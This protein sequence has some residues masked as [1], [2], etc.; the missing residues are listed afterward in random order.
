MDIIYYFSFLYV[1]A[2]FLEN[3]E[4]LNDVKLMF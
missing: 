1:E 4:D 3:C 2:D